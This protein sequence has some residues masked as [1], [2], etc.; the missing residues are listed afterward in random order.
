M[1]HVFI[2]PISHDSMLSFPVSCDSH[3]TC[4]ACH[5]QV[6]CGWCRD[7]A[8]TGLGTCLEGG[9]LSPLGSNSSD[10]SACP[11][12]YWS[13]EECPGWRGLCMCCA[14]EFQ[15]YRFPLPPPSSSPSPLP[16]P[17]S[18]FPLLLPTACQCNGHSACVNESVC[19]QCQNN[20]QG[21]N[22]QICADG[23]Y[24]N[25]E[26]GGTCTGKMHRL[27]CLCVCAYPCSGLILV[28]ASSLLSAL[29]NFC[30]PLKKMC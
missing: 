3:V 7:P 19:E 6:E 17:L 1:F 16:L 23:Y 27:H 30:F 11:E 4:E 26:G 14:E 22:C 5:A 12:T 18:P 2:S 28:G 29:F 24:G 15:T 13:F 10:S 9:F 25:A 8:D 21:D 20:T